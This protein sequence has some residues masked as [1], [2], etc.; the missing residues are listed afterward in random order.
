MSGTAPTPESSLLPARPRGQ[1]EIGVHAALTSLAVHCGDVGRAAK[2]TGVSGSILQGWRDEDHA[3][4]DRI[5]AETLPRVREAGA[6]MYMAFAKDQA[7]YAQ[8]FMADA[9]RRRDDME[10]RDLSG[11]SRNA[12]VAAG[13]FTT[14][15]AE[16]RG[17]PSLIV[18][19]RRPME[20]I[21]RALRAKGVDIEGQ[22]EEIPFPE[23][24][25]P[26]EEIN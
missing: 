9:H 12:A 15:A 5:R 17:D 21:V 1:T 26:T 11:A 18:E 24:E 6:E 16:L 8:D 20:E 23:P 2:E 7:Q 19:H 3:R 4:Y 22:A 25:S 10:A 13:I 14:K